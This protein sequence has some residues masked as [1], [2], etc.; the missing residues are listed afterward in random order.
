MY[1]ATVL[2]VGGGP[3]GLTLACDLRGKG[4]DAQVIDKAT[5]PATT[6][7]ALGLQARGREILS[8]LGALG[9]LPDRAVH[10][11]ATNILLGQRLL[12]K[13]VVETQ[14]GRINLG[15]LVI[16]Q[17]EIEAQLRRRLAE[18]GAEVQWGHELVGATQDSNGVDVR[19]RTSEGEKAIRTKWLVGCDGAH[20]DM[21]KIMDVQF[22]GWP[23]PET[24][25]LADVQLDWKRR[26]DEGTMW[27][28]PEGIFGVVPL[29]TGLWRI[30]AELRP[31]DPMAQ[32]G[33]G[34][35]TATTDGSPASPEVVDKMKTLL[36]ERAGDTTTRISAA[37]WTSVFRFHRR[38][39]S[40]YRR[41]RMLLAGDAAHIHSALG[42]QGMNTGIGD[43]FNLGWKLACVVRGQAADRLLDTYEAE[44]RPV[45][46]D[47][48]K[49]TSWA[50][51]IL[52]GRTA[53]D[54]LIRDHVFL[55][56]MR[57]PAVQRW[58]VDTGS[59][60]RVSYRGGPLAGA[61]IRSRLSS[62]IQRAPMPGDRGPDAECRLSGTGAMGTLGQQLNAHWALLLFGGSEA[63]QRA[64]AEAARSR[65]ER[66]VRVIR[67]LP[68]GCRSRDLHDGDVADAVLED[69]HSA[70]VGA[71]RPGRHT[72]I[73]LRP[74]GHI[75]W[76]SSRLAPAGLVA[77]LD[78][79][80][81]KSDPEN[82]R[83]SR[84]TS[85]GALTA[86]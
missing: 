56:I 18:L 67:V 50:W 45:A 69:E 29:P 41:Q 52:L 47:V 54:R 39:A 37:S 43:A 22:D 15:P 14:A 85:N 55:P 19:A 64:C 76:R 84:Q 68:A 30:F 1:T 86:S 57:W 20:S 36:R 6:S 53:F 27:L 3:T 77:W 10:A 12:T 59:Q 73:L 11:S 63:E 78:H 62:L 48:I 25:I 46:A 40:T 7:R 75:A 42:G 5:G 65:L 34:A 74:D 71:Y 4:I 44:R 23:F 81:D 49:E 26:T 31:D 79:V 33:H 83:T 16:S 21:R 2:I 35:L 61:S 17:A 82:A 8:R 72:A 38:L 13:F 66:D 58:W 70:V 9:D 60:L 80:L 28:H 24:L 32:A 51:N